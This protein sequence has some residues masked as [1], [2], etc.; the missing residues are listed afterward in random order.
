[1]IKLRIEDEPGAVVVHVAG[2]ID[3]FT[4]STLRKRLSAQLNE[5][6]RGGAVVVDLADVDFMNLAGVRVLLDVQRQAMAQ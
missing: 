5:D 4:A 1:L 2:E 6:T 3:L